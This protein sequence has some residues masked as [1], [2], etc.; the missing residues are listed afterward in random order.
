MEDVVKLLYCEQEGCEFSCKFRTQLSR[1]RL[2]AHIIEKVQKEDKVKII[3]PC[4]EGFMCCKCKGTFTK[5]NN[6]YKWYQFM[7]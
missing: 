2:S 3:V 4:N 6:A 1:H 5:N 7:A